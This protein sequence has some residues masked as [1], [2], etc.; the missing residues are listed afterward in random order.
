MASIKMLHHVA[1]AQ[2][3]SV[4][5]TILSHR[6]PR[7]TGHGVKPCANRLALG[8]SAA[9]QIM[10]NTNTVPLTLGAGP[11]RLV[12]WSELK[13]MPCPTPRSDWLRSGGLAL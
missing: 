11:L 10:V 2:A 13:S 6:V 4:N 8:R 1:I 3:I 12:S 5:L 9:R 7:R